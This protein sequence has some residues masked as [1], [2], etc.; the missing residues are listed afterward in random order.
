M[1]RIVYDRIYYNETPCFR[2]TIDPVRE[3]QS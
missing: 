2:I 1:R 3:S